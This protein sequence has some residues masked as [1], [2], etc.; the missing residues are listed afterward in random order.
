LPPGEQYLAFAT[1]YLDGGEHLDPEF[2]SGIRNLAVPFTLGEGEKRAL[3]L[4]VV[5]R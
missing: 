5:E 2:L 3:E 4:K 1:D